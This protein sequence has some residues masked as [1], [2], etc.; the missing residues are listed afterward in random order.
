MSVDGSS[1][2]TRLWLFGSFAMEI[3]GK[4]VRLPTHKAEG[5]LAYLVLHR[6]LQIREQLAAL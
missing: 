1:A 3:K 2:K 4:P 5:L 6:S